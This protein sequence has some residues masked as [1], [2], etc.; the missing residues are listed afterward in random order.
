[1]IN[2]KNYFLIFFGIENKINCLSLLIMD[3]FWI[4]FLR[5]V[6]VLLVKE[7][8]DVVNIFKGFGIKLFY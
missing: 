2:G 5:W 4:I 3:K 6:F 7:F 8:V 1:M